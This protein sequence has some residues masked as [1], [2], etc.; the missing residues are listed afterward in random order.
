MAVNFTTLLRGGFPKTFFARVKSKYHEKCTVLKL[1]SKL[2]LRLFY[3]ARP[4]KT[5]LVESFLASL[6]RPMQ[7]VLTYTG[8]TAS[9]FHEF[10]SR[11][12]GQFLLKVRWTTDFTKESREPFH[13][14]FKP[15]LASSGQLFLF[16]SWLT[17][18]H[19]LGNFLFVKWPDFW[20]SFELF[21]Q[22][23]CGVASFLVSWPQLKAFFYVKLDSSFRT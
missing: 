21:L 7:G 11:T 14:K 12:N 22:S 6:P 16:R 1:F 19:S 23:K 15:F 4:P 17:V 2:I 20:R 10:T 8:L 5:E 18:S 9:I 3:V 13:V